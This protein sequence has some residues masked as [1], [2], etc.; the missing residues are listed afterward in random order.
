MTT[1]GSSVSFWSRASRSAWTWNAYTG[2]SRCPASG[3]SASV[4]SR[5]VI[6][7]VQD[8]LGPPD[9]H[10]GGPPRGRG[11]GWRGSASVPVSRDR[12]AGRKELRPDLPRRPG[13]RRRPRLRLGAVRRYHLL[14]RAGVH[15]LLE[16]APPRGGGEDGRR[17]RRHR[18][19]RG[20]LARPGLGRD[21]VPEPGKE[22][23]ALRA[24]R[25]GRN[26]DP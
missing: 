18:R 21:V 9:H 24:A 13:P 5:E 6:D 3:A 25:H 15:R 14:V 20:R 22:G 11:R 12:E 17:R 23:R 26:P 1:S 19:G 8:T 7:D 16:D 4:S 2:T 10:P